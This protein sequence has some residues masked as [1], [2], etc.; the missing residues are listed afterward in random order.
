M[1]NMMLERNKKFKPEE[2][3]SLHSPNTKNETGRFLELLRNEERYSYYVEEI[4]NG[5]G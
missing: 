4:L 5:T 1:G 2:N 3:I